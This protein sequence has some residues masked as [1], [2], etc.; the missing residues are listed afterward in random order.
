M[1]SPAAPPT[2]M[3]PPSAR[4]TAGSRG[5]GMHCERGPE[6]LVERA[7]DVVERVWDLNGTT[8]DTEH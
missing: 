3:P 5:I 4:G 1:S 8:L 7:A 6:M 2:P